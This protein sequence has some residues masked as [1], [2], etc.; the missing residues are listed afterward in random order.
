MVAIAPTLSN[1]AH[2]GVKMSSRYRCTEKSASSSSA[3]VAR[4]LQPAAETSR[5]ES[6]IVCSMTMP[7]MRSLNSSFLHLSS[8]TRFSIDVAA[9]T[10]PLDS[11]LCNVSTAGRTFSERSAASCGSEGGF[12][13]RPEV[14]CALSLCLFF[15]FALPIV[16]LWAQRSQWSL[17]VMLVARR[18]ISA[19]DIQYMQDRRLSSASLRAQLLLCN[20]RSGHE[21]HHLYWH[22]QEVGHACVFRQFTS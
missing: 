12:T 22:K 4:M 2:S 11:A 5:S 9:V 20:G 7:T 15:F 18:S 21:L 19:R 3:R 16:V 17:G 6:L 13:G 8:C 10:L 14:G 1:S